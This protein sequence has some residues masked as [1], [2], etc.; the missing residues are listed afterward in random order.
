[1][2]ITRQVLDQHSWE[3]WRAAWDE[4][5]RGYTISKDLLL[6]LIPDVFSALRDEPGSLLAGRG[7][8]KPSGPPGTSA[9]LGARPGERL[10]RPGV[11]LAVQRGLGVRRELESPPEMLPSPLGIHLDAPRER[12][13]SDVKPTGTSASSFRAEASLGDRWRPRSLRCSRWWECRAELASRSPCADTIWISK[14]RSSPGGNSSAVFRRTRKPLQLSACQAG[15]CSPAAPLRSLGSLPPGLPLAACAQ[16][17][18]R[19]LRGGLDS[20]P[21]ASFLLPLFR[22]CRRDV[23][24][25]ESSPRRRKGHH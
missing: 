7:C 6:H 4:D 14:Y 3:Y 1:M 5:A 11:A 13:G 20:Q 23:E 21:P 24:R 16:N 2:D 19:T 22:S 10:T 8:G 17:V 18:R 25:I 15:M 9:R 12:G